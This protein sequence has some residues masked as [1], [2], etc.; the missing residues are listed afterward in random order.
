MRAKGFPGCW[1]IAPKRPDFYKFRFCFFVHPEIMPGDSR[2]MKPEDILGGR[3]RPFHAAAEFLSNAGMGVMYAVPYASG[4]SLLLEEIG[5]GHLDHIDWFLLDFADGAFVY[6]SPAEFFRAW[7]GSGRPSRGNEWD[8]GIKKRMLDLDERV[9][10][11][12][13]LNELFFTGLVK[14]VLKKPV[15]DPYDVDAFII[16]YSQKHILPVE[17]KEKFPFTA[18]RGENFSG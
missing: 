12:L 3:Y 7:E 11:E 8:A 1:L 18:T 4:G 9:L 2:D 13:M 10:M 14:T 5:E 15:S 16:S 6:K 17:I